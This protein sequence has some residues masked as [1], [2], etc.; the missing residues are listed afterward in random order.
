MDIQKDLSGRQFGWW[1]VGTE[2]KRQNGRRKWLCTCRCGAKRYVNEGNLKSGKSQ[3][4][5]CFSMEKAIQAAPD[6][7]GEHFGKLT[8]L[9]QAEKD[10]K[11]RLCWECQCD[12]GAVCVATHR[13]LVSGKKKSCGCSKREPTRLTNLKNKRFGRLLVL[14][15]TGERSYKGSVLW[16]CRCDCGNELVVSADALTGGKY[17]SCGCK[18]QEWQ[19]TIYTTLH[20]V[21]GTCVES[22]SRKVRNDNTSGHPGVYRLQNGHYRAIIGFQKKNYS[23]GTF[24]N[25]DEAVKVREEAEERLHKSFLR[26]YFAW[27]EKAEEDPQ[28]AAGNPFVF[29]RQQDI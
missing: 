18:R 12:C 13:A 19:R 1:T 15:N 20:H 26:E 16:R 5:G 27:K 23:L 24:D 9:R 14:E 2:W 22:L 10:D 6:L 21:D 4:C 25:F 11:G 17:L 29:Q 7:T 28:W 8:V 3:S